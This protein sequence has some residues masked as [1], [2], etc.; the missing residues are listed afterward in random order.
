MFK[1]TSIKHVP[2]PLERHSQEN[3]HLSDFDKEVSYNKS[4]KTD[5]YSQPHAGNEGYSDL[6]DDAEWVKKET[7][8][9]LDSRRSAFGLNEETPADKSNSEPTTTHRRVSANTSIQT[10]NLTATHNNSIDERMVGQNAD[11][12]YEGQQKGADLLVPT[13]IIIDAVLDQDIKS[14]YTGP[15]NGHLVQDVYS[16][17]NQYILFPKGTQ[18]TGQSLHIANVNEPIQNR[19]G[20]TVEWA[21]LPNGK[22]ID[23]HKHVPIDQAGVAA[24]EG[25][26]NRHLLAQ[27]LSVIAYATI[28]GEAPRDQINANGF[29]QPTFAG[30]FAD[31]FREATI[32]YVMKYLN[33]VPT[34]TLQAGM[35]IKI[36]TQ[37]D[38]YVH[39]W[40]RVNSTVYSTGE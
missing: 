11:D 28:S 31:G 25:D 30:Q 3:Y 24:F 34:V 18:V 32:P 5:G 22:R 2:P 6:D 23:F 40:A 16:I 14:D 13:G 8:R 27:F 1:T 19:L 21:I 9:A 10:D 35:P 39:P 15:W 17:D 12:V 37:D 29:T 33:L 7:I 4:V 36:H 26:V 38:M 20:L